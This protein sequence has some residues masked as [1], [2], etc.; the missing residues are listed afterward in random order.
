M[1]A[2]SKTELTAGVVADVLAELDEFWCSDCL[3][4]AL[5]ERIVDAVAGSEWAC[6]A[7]GAAYLDAIDLVVE[8]A[9]GARGVA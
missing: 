3:S 8:P 2:E 9:R 4:L 5:F 7:C 1:K 6:T